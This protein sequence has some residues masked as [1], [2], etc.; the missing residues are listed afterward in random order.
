[1]A[2]GALVREFH[3]HTNT[4]WNSAFTTDG[5]FVL[6]ASADKSARMWDVRTGQQVRYFPGHASSSVSDVAVSP[7]G[8]QVAVAS[9]DGSVQFTP[10]D[11]GGLLTSVCDRLVRDLTSDERAIY[12]IPGDRPTCPAE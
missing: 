1:V 4:I 6:T 10:A 5:R 3:G 7:D 9:F 12:G 2:T 11:A 8:S